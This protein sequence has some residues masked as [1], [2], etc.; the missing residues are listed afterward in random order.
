MLKKRTIESKASAAESHA[1]HGRIETRAARFRGQMSV[2]SR[3][4]DA[5]HTLAG[6]STS[7]PFT[8]PRHLSPLKLAK[9]MSSPNLLL[10]GAGDVDEYEGMSPLARLIIAKASPRSRRSSP[11]PRRS[12]SRFSPASGGGRGSSPRGL[13]PR[14]R[15]AAR[16]SAN[17]TV[18]SSPRPGSAS[19][20]RRFGEKYG[21]PRTTGS[22]LVAPQKSSY[23]IAVERFQY[24][25]EERKK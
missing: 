11:S 17:R 14:A 19:P 6:D 16:A 7:T 13:S 24:L 2:D 23:Q 12:G 5:M 8:T 25:L 3:E 9:I 4:I 10:D 15:A 21:S 1:T 18:G 20:R 22:P